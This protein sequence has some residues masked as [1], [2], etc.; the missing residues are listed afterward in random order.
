MAQALR[1]DIEPHSNPKLGDF[2]AELTEL[3]RNHGIALSN[4]EL[5]EMESDDYAFSYEADARSRLIRA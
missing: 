3:S 5:F 2:L 4:A 1:A